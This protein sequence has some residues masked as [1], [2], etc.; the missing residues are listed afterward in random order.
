MLYGE[1]TS[2]TAVIHA[3]KACLIDPD[4]ENLILAKSNLLQIFRI[5]TSVRET[6]L[7]H[8]ESGRNVIGDAVAET[9]LSEDGGE[10]FMGDDS[11]VQLLLHENV[12]QLILVHEIKLSGTVTGIVNTGRMQNVATDADCIAIS[13]ED[14]KVSHP[15]CT[16]LP[17]GF[18]SILGTGSPLPYNFVNTFLRKRITQIALFLF[19]PTPLI[20]RLPFPMSHPT[21]LYRCLRHPSHSTA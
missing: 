20:Q 16:S 5:Q 18:C 4:E 13:F 9:L 3:I 1:L 17:I 8:S 7:R 21:G 2:P 14:A 19:Y 12:G 15:R 6:R 10:D 11:Q